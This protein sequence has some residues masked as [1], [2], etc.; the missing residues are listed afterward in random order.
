MAVLLAIVGTVMTA[1]SKEAGAMAAQ[2]R[3]GT[4]HTV[5]CQNL[6]TC[7]GQ[8]ERCFFGKCGQPNLL[9]FKIVAKNIVQVKLLVNFNLCNLVFLQ[10][11]G[12]F[13]FVGLGLPSKFP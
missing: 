9:F 2:V 5:L 4:I 12:E 3:K 8:A 7:C 1:M 10:T 11:I 13:Q 6:E